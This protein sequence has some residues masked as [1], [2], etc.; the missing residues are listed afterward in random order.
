MVISKEVQILK[1]INQGQDV[2]KLKKKKG[3]F[4]WGEKEKKKSS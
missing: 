3:R 4:R 1:P 2:L